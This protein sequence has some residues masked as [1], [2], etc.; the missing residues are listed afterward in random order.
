M[1]T[2]FGNE[3]VMGDCGRDN[4]H[5]IVGTE[6]SL[7]GVRSDREVRSLAKLFKKL[8]CGGDK[9]YK[10]T[11]EGKQRIRKGGVRMGQT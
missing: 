6:A 7:S 3:K 2:G 5:G 10:V 8:D 4:S 11:A 9:R 1:S